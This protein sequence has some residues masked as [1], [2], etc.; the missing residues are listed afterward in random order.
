MLVYKGCDI[1][2]WRDRFKGENCA[3]VFLHY[4]DASDEKAEENKYDGRIFLGL[5]S[6]FSRKHKTSE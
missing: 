5:P 3:Q 1:E 2:H 6:Y 4:N